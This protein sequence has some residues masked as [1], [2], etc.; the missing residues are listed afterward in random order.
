L[1][2]TNLIKAISALGNSFEGIPLTTENGFQLKDEKSV[3]KSIAFCKPDFVIHT[4]AIADVDYCETHPGEAREVNALGSSFVAKACEKAG[5]KLVAISTDYAFD[6]RKGNYA[7]DDATNPLGYY[8][9]SKLEG[10]EL[11]LENSSSVIVARTAWLYGTGGARKSFPMWVAGEL[12]EGRGIKAVVDN[13]STPTLASDLA[14]GLLDLLSSDFSGILHC[15]GS[16]RINR[17]DWAKKI[18]ARFELDEALVSPVKSSELSWKS[19]RPFDSSLNCSKFYS[20]IGRKLVGTDGGLE[21]L[22][23]Q[24]GL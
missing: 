3:E 14:S 23:K 10:E 4:A 24:A 7:E 9:S 5:A 19:K 18:A 11:V 17:F 2:G 15:A 22:A 16:E 20:L 8:A 12:R 6:G 21:S 1:L 13:F